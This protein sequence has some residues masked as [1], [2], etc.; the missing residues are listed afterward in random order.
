MESIALH[1]GPLS[2]LVKWDSF[3]TPLVLFFFFGEGG[4]QVHCLSSQKKSVT[5]MLASSPVKQPSWSPSLWSSAGNED[6]QRGLSLS[7]NPA[8][9]M[10]ET[11]NSVLRG[12]SQLSSQNH[13]RLPPSSLFCRFHLSRWWHHA[14][15]KR[16][17]ARAAA[18]A[19]ASLSNR[20][21]HLLHIAPKEATHPPIWRN[22]ILQSRA[23]FHSHFCLPPDLIMASLHPV[24]CNALPWQMA[25]VC[26]C[27]GVQVCKTWS[28]MFHLCVFNGKKSR[29]HWNVR[30]Q[31]ENEFNILSVL[32]GRRSKELS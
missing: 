29:L 3:C 18:I 13:R 24:M 26:R 20:L 8:L 28:E 16:C 7:S 31:V 6:A 21:V 22:I 25:D 27:L 17:A 11:I 14:P 10:H 15:F 2:W 23:D 9:I 1:G 5:L 12:S 30:V 4:A 19:V 32:C